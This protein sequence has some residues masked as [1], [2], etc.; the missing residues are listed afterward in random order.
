MYALLGEDDSDAEMLK[1]LVRRLVGSHGLRIRAKGFGGCGKLLNDG[2]RELRNFRRLNYTRFVVC[3][4]ADR[5][6]PDAVRQTV[7]ERVV[8]PA[9]FAPDCCIVVPVQEIEAWILADLAKVS[10]VLTGWRPEPIAHPESVPDP[11]EHLEKLS[12]DSQRRSRYRCR[13]HNARIAEHLDLEEVARKCPSFRVL[14]DF[15]RS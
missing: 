12:R 6:D 11:S 8:R 5:N 15:V 3:H 4:D 7:E 13:I 10:L 9:R 14:R 2:A 1:V